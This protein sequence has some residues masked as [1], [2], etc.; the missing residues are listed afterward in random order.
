MFDFYFD[1]KEIT[2]LP[3]K[4]DDKFFTKNFVVMKIVVLLQSD[5]AEV[6]QLVERNLA[7]VEVA[8]SNLVFRSH[9]RCH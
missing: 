7:K 4:K 1:C 9:S 3:K 8:S 6:A 2:F 5:S